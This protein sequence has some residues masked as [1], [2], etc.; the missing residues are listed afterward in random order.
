LEISEEDRAVP[1]A[2]VSSS[3]RPEESKATKQELLTAE[4]RRTRRTTL[5][6][7][8]GFHG[9]GGEGSQS[10]ET[11]VGVDALHPDNVLEPHIKC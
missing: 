3:A 8:S 11:A 7:F 5:K 9:F 2:I 10:G 6:F 4:L 1:T